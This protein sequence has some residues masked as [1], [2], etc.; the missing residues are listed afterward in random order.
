MFVKRL[1]SMPVETVWDRRLCT[2]RARWRYRW[3]ERRPCRRA[4]M[5]RR[6]CSGGGAVSGCAETARLC[7]LRCGRAHRQTDDSSW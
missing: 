2:S 7:R 1:S 6:S 3:K 4:L 5:N